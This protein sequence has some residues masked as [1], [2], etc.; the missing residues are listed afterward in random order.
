[1]AFTQIPWIIAALAVLITVHEYGHYRMAVACGV[2]VL[3]FSFGF[4][5]VLWRRQA[6]PGATEFVVSALPLGGY[7]RMLGD[8]DQAVSAADAGRTLEGRPLWQRA[9]VVLAGP[10][11]NLL[12]AVLLFAGA[13]AL[14]TREA[15]AVL[16][17]PPPSS[18][19]AQA[20]I[21]SGDRVL[22]AATI[23]APASLDDADAAGGLR[24]ADADLSWADVRSI[25]ELFDRVATAVLDHR[26]LRLRVQSADATAPHDATL[27]LD[28]L[29]SRDLTGDTLSRLIGLDTRVP[30]VLSA[31][32]PAGPAA[33]AGLRAGDRVVRVDDAPV[34]DVQAFLVHIRGALHGTQAAP[35]RIEVLR[36]GAP[37]ITLV[38]PR[39]MTQDGN[40][41]ARID[42]GFD[43]QPEMTLVRDTPLVALGEGA[44]RTWQTAA[45]S[46]RTLAHMLVGQASVK[47]LSGPITIAQVAGQTASRGFAHYLAFLATVSVSLGVL[48]L[49]PLPIL[50]GGRLLYYLWEGVTGRPVPELWL[51]RLQRGG[52]LILLLLMSLALSNDVARLMGLQ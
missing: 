9:L 2:K 32:T 6:H 3:R 29:A 15:A 28:H 30:P 17:T 35:L 45:V 42:V 31:P 52:L 25:E 26:A 4:G 13:R 36:G 1:M 21:V 47:N 10:L 44:V 37:F 39:V 51:A 5:R 41:Q 19:M 23:D 22:A 34:P 40:R 12:L 50:D 48:N 20:G 8:G 27:R 24:D 11:A 16:G 14:G 49:L 38:Q 46:L 33:S 18:L 7:V 43:A